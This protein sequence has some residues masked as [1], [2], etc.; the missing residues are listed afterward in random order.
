M[1]LVIDLLTHDAPVQQLQ[2]TLPVRLGEFAPGFQLRER[3]TGITAVQFGKLIALAHPG[4]FAAAERNDPFANDA[5][6]LGPT[7]G[8]HHRGRI[9]NFGGAAPVRLDNL[10]LRRAAYPPIGRRNSGNEQKKQNWK[11]I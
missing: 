7:D 6:D 8:L 4:P 11:A 1:C 10:D 9:N 5:C 2:R 3:C